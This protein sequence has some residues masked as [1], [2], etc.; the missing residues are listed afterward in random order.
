MVIDHIFTVISACCILHNF[1]EIHGEVF[2]EAWLDHD[3]PDDQQPGSSAIPTSPSTSLDSP[4]NV[5]NTLMQFWYAQ[6]SC[7]CCMYYMYITQS[8]NYKL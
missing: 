1:G 4:Q 8:H 7:F 3:S 5:C 6:Q 2:N